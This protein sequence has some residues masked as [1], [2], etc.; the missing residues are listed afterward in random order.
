MMG[1]ALPLV[2]ELG[3]HKGVHKLVPAIALSCSLA[4]C[5]LT[6]HS[7]HMLDGSARSVTSK[8]SIGQG[9]F[10]HLQATNQLHC[11]HPR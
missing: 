2:L 1:S 6:A 3:L 7:L 11:K 10:S 4:L 5:Q 9:S 8:H